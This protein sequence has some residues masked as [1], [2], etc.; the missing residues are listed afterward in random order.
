MNASSPTAAEIE[1]A[2]LQVLRPLLQRDDIDRHDSF[3]DLGADSALIVE[4]RVHLSALLG[5]ELS[6]VDLF[7]NPNVASLAA[8]LAAQTGTSAQEQGAARART[9]A[10]RLAGRRAPRDATPSSPAED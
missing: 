9:R 6:D 8:Y 2:I 3:F 7:A 4:A 5:R 10:A 1:R